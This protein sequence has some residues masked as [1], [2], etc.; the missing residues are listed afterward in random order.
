VTLTSPQ[1]PQRLGWRGLHF[2][3]ESLNIDSVPSLT[4]SWIW[5]ESIANLQSQI[6]ALLV[7]T[8]RGPGSLYAE[9]VEESE[10]SPEVGWDAHVRL[11]DELCVAERAFLSERK[12]K[13][14]GDFSRYVGVD[15]KE[16]REEDIPI[17]GIAASGGGGCSTRSPWYSKRSVS[18]FP[19]LPC[20]DKY[21]R[22]ARWCTGDGPIGLCQ[23]HRWD[24]W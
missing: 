12:R 16:V 10:K 1:E 3:R 8:G 24:I 4:A 11:G 9:I 15:E 7:A 2:I 19:R 23:L 21:H 17:V 14:K 13:M 20:D 22:I 6:Q 18:S 5:P